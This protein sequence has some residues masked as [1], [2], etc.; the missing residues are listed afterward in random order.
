MMVNWLAFH[1]LREA[2]RVRDWLVLFASTLVVIE[3]ARVSW[4]SNARHR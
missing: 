3:F 2:H 4:N 1:D